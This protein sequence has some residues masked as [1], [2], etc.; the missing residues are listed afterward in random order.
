MSFLDKEFHSDYTLKYFLQR[1]PDT[2]LLLYNPIFNLKNTTLETDLIL[3]SPLGIEIIRLVEYQSSITIVAGDD[4]TWFLEENN[5]RS[6]II[7]PMISLKR[8]EKVVKSI[9]SKYEINFPIKKTILSRN[10]LI[11]YNTEP[12]NTQYIGSDQHEKWLT[13]KRNFVSPLKH[14]QLK[15]CDCLLKHCYTTS[16]R[17]PEWDEDKDVYQF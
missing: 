8:T 4:R 16:V 9:L 14:L 11:E 12:F 6:R 2:Y 10:N 15:V 7:S 5:I 13:D 3:I 1:F 17:R